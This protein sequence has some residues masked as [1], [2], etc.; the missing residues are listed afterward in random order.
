M[1]LFALDTNLL[2]YT[3]NTASSFNRKAIAFLDKVMNERDEA[4]KLSVC[5]PLQV[6]QEFVHVITW[7]RLEHPLSLSEAV[8]V[9][10]D[11]V[12]TGV[13]IIYPRETQLQTFVGL[14]EDLDNP[15]KSFRCSPGRNTEG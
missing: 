5:I 11:Y 6:F 14:V 2:V 13:T 1:N 3:H 10:E 7:Q 9:V 8:Q 15:P 12:D 4:G